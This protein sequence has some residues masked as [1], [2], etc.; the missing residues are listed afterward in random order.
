MGRTKSAVPNSMALL[1]HA[2][3]TELFLSCAIVRAPVFLNYNYPLAP[4]CPMP[5]RV[6]P[7]DL[8]WAADSHGFKQNIH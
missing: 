7:M 3:I 6:T 1:G 8:S 2:K 4:S 5:V